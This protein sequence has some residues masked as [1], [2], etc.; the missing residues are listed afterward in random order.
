MYNCKSS[1]DGND[2]LVTTRHVR[3]DRPHQLGERTVTSGNHRLKANELS[4]HAFVPRPV[5]INLAPL[6]VRTTLRAGQFLNE[7]PT[8]RRTCV[9]SKKPVSALRSSTSSSISSW[10]LG[11]VCSVTLTRTGVTHLGSPSSLNATRKVVLFTGTTKQTRRTTLGAI[12]MEVIMANMNH[13]FN[14]AR[15]FFR[16]KQQ[17]TGQ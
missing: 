15:S 9:R 3:P 16:N 13:N 4:F 6:A 11:Q 7:K 1:V 12:N 14:Q 17:N 8:A 2:K 5:F 10:S